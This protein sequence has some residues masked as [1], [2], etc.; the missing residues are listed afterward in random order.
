M[1]VSL[2]RDR[3]DPVGVAEKTLCRRFRAEKCRITRSSPMLVCPGIKRRSNSLETVLSSTPLPQTHVEYTT[4]I[5]TDSSIPADAN[6]GWE[7]LKSSSGAKYRVKAADYDITDKPTD[8]ANETEASGPSFKD[9][10]VNW[11]LGTEGV[12]D[13]DVQRRTAITWYK[14]AEAEWYSPFKYK[15]TINCKDTYCYFFTDKD[16]PKPDKY[17]LNVFQNPGT[18]SLEFGSKNPTI[19]SISSW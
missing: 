11:K 1:K 3:D 14:L 17:M 9:V 7:E 19:T 16:E 15:L 10:R 5:M 18:H 6:V 12:P 8:E 2:L 13:E 4:F